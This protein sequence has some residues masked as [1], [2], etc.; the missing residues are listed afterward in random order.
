MALNLQDKL[1]NLDWFMVT[2]VSLVATIG[3]VVLY[4]AA[5]GNFSPWAFKQM[6]R[7]VLGFGLMTM[8]AF[9][10]IRFFRNY[11][12]V[13][14][15]ISFVLL[16]FVDLKGHIGMGGQR[17][18]DLYVFHLQ[19]SEL[20]KISLL[21]A[22]AHYFHTVPPQNIPKLKTYIFPL[23]LIALPS[24]LVLRQPDLGTMIILAATG[25]TVIFV[26]GISYWKIAVS[27]LTLIASFPILWSRMYDYQKKRILTFLNPE[28]DPLGSGYHVVQSKIAIGSGGLWGKGFLSGTQ[29]QLSFLPEKQTD[30]IFAMYCEEF[31]VA[32]GLF[33][34]GLYGILVLYGYRIT[35]ECRSL[36]GRL[37]AAGLTTLLFLSVFV[38]IAMVMGLLP[39]VGVP[40][41]FMSYG[42][43]SMLTMMLGIGILLSISLHRNMRFG[44]SS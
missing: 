24:L 9:S 12:Y 10:D 6:G 35:L 18:I 31:G 7:F 37:V 3:F 23:I 13:F 28:S 4:S 38:N 22:L 43:T 1:K 40:L 19:P 39:V 14:Y 26:V 17:W 8:V 29:S 5:G 25:L 16:I 36:F 32:G 41:P 33:L 15:A 21:I 44:R 11:A 20:M 30:F 2:S 34:L 42:G 27:L